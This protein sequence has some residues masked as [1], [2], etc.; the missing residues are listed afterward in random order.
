[1]E[2]SDSTTTYLVLFCIGAALLVGTALLIRTLIHTYNHLRLYANRVREANSNVMV[3]LQKKAG[4]VNQLINVAGAY[5]HH[6]QFI[7]VAV[8]QNLNMAAAVD[9]YENLN[10]NL[11]R[12]FAVAAAFP[13]LHANQT[14]QQLMS[15]LQGI[16]DEL[17][18]K[19]EQYNHLVLEYNS[20]RGAFPMIL[21]ATMLGYSDVPYFA[22]TSEGL[23]QLR[24]AMS[25]GPALPV[26]QPAAA[27]P[28]PRD[29]QAVARPPARVAAHVNVHAA[30]GQL[31]GV[32]GEGVGRVVSLSDG[33][34][35]GRASTCQL[36]LNDT[37]ISRQ[38]TRLRF[39]N[40][41]WFVQDLDS[42][43]GTY[44]NGNRV[45]AAALNPGDRIR[46]GATELEFRA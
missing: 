23:G 40:G 3:M 9:A 37:S 1:M 41:R 4:L 20:A 17:Q 38:H 25:D 2:G 44:V 10:N 45:Q 26:H 24:A 28:M 27:L 8:A 46:V 6:E 15:Q 43:A 19:R 36:R 5:A 30:G 39:S 16:E 33:F 13:E 42:R 18:K 22:D 35:I 21:F 31:I 11:Q 32:S 12:V 7:H 14:F 34:L 29:V